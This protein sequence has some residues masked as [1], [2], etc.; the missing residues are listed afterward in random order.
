MIPQPVKILQGDV[1]ERLADLPDESVHCVVTSPPY[2]GLRSY[3]VD[4]QIGLEATPEEYVERIVGVFREVRRVLRG[5]GTCWVNLGDSYNGYMANQRATSISAHNQHARPFFAKGHGPRT[6][7]LKPKD[8]V[9]I[10]WRVAFALQTDGWWLRSDIVWAKPNPM[11]ESVT[12]RPTKAHEFVFLLTKA[13]RYFY[14]QEAVREPHK[15][16][17]LERIK[18]GLKHRHPDG[19]GV[20]IPPVDL[21]EMGERFAHPNGRNLRT[22]WNIATQPLKDAHFASFPEELVRRC[23]R[24]GSPTKVCAECGAGWVRE[25][26]RKEYGDWRSTPRDQDQA[27]GN[28]K[29]DDAYSKGEYE[30]PKTLGFRPA[31][32]CKAETAPATILD[33]FAGSGTTGR[34]CVQENRDFIGI[35]LNAA[36]CEMAERRTRNV[37]RGLLC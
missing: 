33:P 5:D 30:P 3:G 17:T 24:A 10:P 2:W 37:Q 12:D 31:C 4:G 7:S 29:N 20:G 13:A 35:E 26:E 15:P 25:V 27:H 16:V 1:L 6:R 34:V 11:P 22:V 23:I 36:Y 14:D 32:E 18:S 8:L 9:G 21:E 28:V 19:I